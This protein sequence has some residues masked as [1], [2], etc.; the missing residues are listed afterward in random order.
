MAI[1]A[2]YS[3]S[4]LPHK[5]APLWWQEQGLQYTASGYGGKI[6]TSRMVQLPSS[7]RWR[8]VYCASYGNAGTCYV[9]VGKD[10]VVIS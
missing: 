2:T 1:I 3:L 10:W 9:Q 8:H 6:P 4:D 5:R 7:K